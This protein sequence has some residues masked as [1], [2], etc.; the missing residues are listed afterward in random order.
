MG[1]SGVTEMARVLVVDDSPEIRELLRAVLE[2]GGHEVREASSYHD[3]VFSILRGNYDVVIA[4]GHFPMSD[5]E[6][7]GP[8]GPELLRRISAYCRIRILHSADDTLN[9]NMR[10]GGIKVLPKRSSMAEILVAVEGRS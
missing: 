1:R 9:S 8:L 5:G 4:D 6:R 10:E 7:V 2:R 3:A